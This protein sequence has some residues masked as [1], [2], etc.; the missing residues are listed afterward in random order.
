MRLRQ[1]SAIH[2]IGVVPSASTV[3]TI[4]GIASASSRIC[5]SRRRMSS[6]CAAISSSVSIPVIASGGVG[7]LDHLVDGVEKG[8]AS[9]VLADDR[10]GR[11]TIQG[12]ILAEVQ[13]LCR[14]RGTALIWITHDLSVIA[15]ASRTRRPK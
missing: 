3:H 14:E 11:V 10:R 15:E 5:C 9:A 12:Q 1:S 4:C 13:K 2:R 8:H 6:F 7:N